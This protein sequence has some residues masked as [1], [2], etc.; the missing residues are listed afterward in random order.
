MI[1][2]AS[3]DLA[4]FRG[5]VGTLGFFG[6]GRVVVA[7]DLFASSARRGR[8]SKDW[9]RPDSA[10]AL[11]AQVPHETTVLVVERELDAKLEQ[12]FGK[13]CRT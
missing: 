6:S 13:R 12:R 8:K 7:R 10:V 2:D 9:P 3:S 5:A 4:A 1:D 11:L